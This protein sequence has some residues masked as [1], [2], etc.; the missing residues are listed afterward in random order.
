[1]ADEEKRRFTKPEDLGEST[2]KL[3][4]NTAS[5]GA[6]ARASESVLGE[7]SDYHATHPR[8]QTGAEE[9][10]FPPASGANA[11]G[12]NKPAE[13][14]SEASEEEFRKEIQELHKERRAG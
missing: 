2:N 7:D 14:S 10:G 6:G 13:P 4:A 9:P 11:I 3:G 1:M 5:P 12:P 8:T